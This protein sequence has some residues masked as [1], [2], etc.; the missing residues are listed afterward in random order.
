[1]PDHLYGIALAIRA[2]LA[3]RLS[4]RTAA[5]ALIPLLLPLRDQL[6]G[7]A[8]TSFVSRPFAH[9]LGEMY[10]LLG[11]ESEALAQFAHAEKVA[12]QWESGHLM[13]AARR[14]AA[15]TA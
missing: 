5:Q 12:R 3:F 6:A 2:E 9:S 15:A 11:D 7:A 4:D 1:V 13:A 14:S 10:R 8:S